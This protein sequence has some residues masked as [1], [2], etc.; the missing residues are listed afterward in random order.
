MP[1]IDGNEAKVT[2]CPF[3]EKPHNNQPD[4]MYSLCI[5]TISGLFNCFRC[6]Q[7][8]NWYK[9]KNLFG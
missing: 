9:F 7:S 3:C 8:G 4:N 1:K 5:N 6:G 2:F